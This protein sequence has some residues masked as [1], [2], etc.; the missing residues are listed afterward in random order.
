MNNFSKSFLLNSGPAQVA[1]N[2]SL[3]SKKWEFKFDQ[4]T[5]LVK[6]SGGQKKAQKVANVIAGAIKRVGRL[7]NLARANV[8]KIALS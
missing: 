2:Y 7:D 3:K 6:M 4:T 8:D 1:Y 5:L